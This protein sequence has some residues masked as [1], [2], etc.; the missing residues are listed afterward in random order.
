MYTFFF[1]YIEIFVRCLKEKSELSR[2]IYYLRNPHLFKK[3]LQIQ[4]W[5]KYVKFIWFDYLISELS[6]LYI[7]ISLKYL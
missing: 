1:F 5:T 3:R 7:K 6:T 4:A 2:R